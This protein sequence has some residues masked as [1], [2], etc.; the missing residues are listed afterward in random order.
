M[1]NIYSKVNFLM[2]SDVR[3]GAL[4]VTGIEGIPNRAQCTLNFLMI[5]F[6]SRFDK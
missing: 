2:E 5:V 6:D 4:S 3:L 1:V